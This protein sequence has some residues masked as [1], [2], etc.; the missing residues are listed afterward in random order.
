MAVSFKVSSLVKN[1]LNVEILLV[2]VHTD[3]CAGWLSGEL[4]CYIILSCRSNCIA[5]CIG[6]GNLGLLKEKKINWIHFPFFIHALF[7]STSVSVS[8]P[9]SSPQFFKFIITLTFSLP[10]GVPAPPALISLPDGLSIVSTIWP[11]FSLY[12]SVTCFLSK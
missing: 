10:F 5:G 7:M 11:L 4:F 12:L 3:Y 2:Q 6:N 9:V 1:V 8:H